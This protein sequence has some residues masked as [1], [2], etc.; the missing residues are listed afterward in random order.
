MQKSSAPEYESESEFEFESGCSGLDE[1]SS[2][3]L[4]FPLSCRTSK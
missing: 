2:C 1:C 3:V 4:T